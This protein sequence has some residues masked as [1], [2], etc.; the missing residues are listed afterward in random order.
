MPF[1]SQYDAQSV[2]AKVQTIGEGLQLVRTIADSMSS[3]TTT[4]R[5]LIGQMRRL[6]QIYNEIV[7]L[8]QDPSIVAIRTG[9]ENTAIAAVKTALDDL[10]LSF[11]D[12]VAT[13]G[14]TNAIDIGSTYNSGGSRSQ[15]LS[16]VNRSFTDNQITVPTSV[17]T[18][19]SNLRDSIDAFRAT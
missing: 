16:A 3:G 10:V 5:L 9:Q 7:P 13:A 18:A 15:K 4:A 11:A 2:D 6:D 14:M 12:L 8:W 19:A 1:N 17:A